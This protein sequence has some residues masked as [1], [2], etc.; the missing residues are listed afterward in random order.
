MDTLILFLLAGVAAWVFLGVFLAGMVCGRY[1]RIAPKSNKPTMAKLI[2]QIK[3]GEIVQCYTTEDIGMRVEVEKDNFLGE[4]V[5]KVITPAE[6][7]RI[8][9]HIAQEN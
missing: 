2:L 5:P 9:A 3:D 8:A 6:Y 7:Q 4:F 1:I